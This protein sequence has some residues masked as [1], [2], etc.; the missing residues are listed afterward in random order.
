VE[1]LE[2][3]RPE[4][5]AT[6]LYC[7]SSAK[8]GEELLAVTAAAAAVELG[9]AAV[10]ALPAALPMLTESRTLPPLLPLLLLQAG[11]LQLRELSLSTVAALLLKRGAPKWQRRGA[12]G[13][14]PGAKPLPLTVSRAPP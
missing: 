6:G 13:A 11:A 7:S 1:P 12:P 10:L 14:A 9:A 2:G 5:A 8:G 4:R 3:H